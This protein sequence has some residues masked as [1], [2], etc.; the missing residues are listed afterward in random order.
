MYLDDSFTFDENGYVIP[1]GVSL[2]DPSICSLILCNYSK[3]K[4]SAFGNFENDTW[5][6]MED[7][8]RISSKALEPYPVYEEIVIRKI[9][10]M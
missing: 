8:D 10:G 5:F 9:D 3:L 6:L 4:E 1:E 2:C 7:F